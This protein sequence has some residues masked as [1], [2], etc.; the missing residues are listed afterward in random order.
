MDKTTKAEILV[1]E[2]EEMLLSAILKK[3][4]ASGYDAKGFTSATE[5]IEYMEKSGSIPSS[6]WLDYYLKDMNG[7]E[8][9]EKLKSRE[10]WSE[11]PVLVVSNSAS[12]QKVSA[13]MSMGVKKYFLKADNKLEEI[14]KSMK[15]VIPQNE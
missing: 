5:A 6:V 11:I 12:E 8:F 7:I 10:E 2:D 1:I 9:M 15:E 13:M 14:I 4:E 3:L